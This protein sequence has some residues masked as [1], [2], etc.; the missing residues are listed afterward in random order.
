MRGDIL[1]S[2][3]QNFLLI[4]LIIL[5]V[6]YYIE[7]LLRSFGVKINLKPLHNIKLLW[8][9]LIFVGLFTVAKN[10]FPVLAPI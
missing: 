9:A 10:I 7:Y 4:T 3:R 2:L 8:T 6:V 5:S 1:L